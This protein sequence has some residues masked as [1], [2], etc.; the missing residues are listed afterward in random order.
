MITV[1][2]PGQPVPKA[3]PRMGRNGVYTPQKTKNH[4]AQIGKLAAPHFS[5]PIE[6]PVSVTVIAQFKP[7]KSWTKKKTAELM[8]S[9]HTQRP[10]LDNIEKA[11]WD[12]LN[13]IAFIDDSQ[14]AES[15]C[16]KFWGPVAQTVIHIKPVKSFIGSA[17]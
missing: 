13:G 2:I 3:R 10:D 16:R 12:G 15:N 6:G 9:P 1:T 8:G 17:F 7:P 5:E 4:E 11:V 14:I